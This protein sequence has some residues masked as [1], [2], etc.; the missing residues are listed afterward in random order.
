MISSEYTSPQI[1]SWLD[2]KQANKV[3]HRNVR[4]AYWT[5]KFLLRF[6]RQSRYIGIHESDVVHGS[7]YVI[8]SNH[9]SMIDPFLI[10]SQVPYSIWR[11]FGTIRYFTANGLFKKRWMRPFLLGLGCF[12]AQ[13]HSKYP[14]GLDYGIRQLKMGRALLIFPEGQRAIRGATRI[15][16]GIQVLAQ[17]PNAMI[18]P[19][20]LEWTQH[21]FGRSFAI[22][23]GKP[24]D[25]SQMA[26][27][28][29]MDRIYA[30]PLK[31]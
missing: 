1:Q 20:H 7:R 25:G 3:I 14:Y 23:I 15:R 5:A 6:L 13:Q 30:V 8:A 18:V 27:E 17:E 16:R 19:V 29:I 2:T 21:R 31:G 24:F 26:A 12:P 22:G 10:G 4:V 28:E 11:H 9:Q